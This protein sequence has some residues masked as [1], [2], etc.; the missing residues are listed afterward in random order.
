MT[1]HVSLRSRYQGVEDGAAAVA[2]PDPRVLL[3]SIVHDFNVLL[4]PVVGILEELQV[5]KGGTTRQLK[6]IDGAIYCAFRARTLA[7]QLLELANPRPAKPASVDIGQLLEL[8]EAPLS[9]LL[10][11]DIR[12]ELVVADDLP[13]AFVDQQSIERA[14]LNLVLNARD[15]MPAGGHVTIAAALDCRSGSHAE[16]RDPMI[17]LSITDCG[18][19]MDERTLTMVGQLHFTT[20]ANGTGLGLATVKQLVEGQGDGLSI[21]STPHRGTTVDLWLPVMPASFAD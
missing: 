1:E 4:T 19:G 16:E 5:R 21:T 14:L 17:R 10:L 12:F 13:K 18:T 15:A 20:K 9:S 11:P 2:M 6:K 3:A 8:L 7:R